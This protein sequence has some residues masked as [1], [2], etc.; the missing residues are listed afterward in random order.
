MRKICSGKKLG[1][2]TNKALIFQKGLN[3]WEEPQLGSQRQKGGQRVPCSRKEVAGVKAEHILFS[4]KLYHICHPKVQP[5]NH[6]RNEKRDS[7]QHRGSKCLHS[8]IR[9]PRGSC[10]MTHTISS[11]QP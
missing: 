6:R 5:P 1:M 7:P 9:E 8:I 11:G 2:L 3:L 10:K 4:W